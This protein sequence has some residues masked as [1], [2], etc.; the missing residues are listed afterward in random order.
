MVNTIQEPQSDVLRVTEL[1]NPPICKKLALEN[2]ETITA[3]ASE[4]LWSLLGTGIHS[5]LA[6]DETGVL[7]EKRIT[8]E[9][10]GAEH[11]LLSGQVDRFIEKTQTIADYKSTSV[12]SYLFGTKPEWEAQLNLYKYLLET[13]GRTVKKLTI[14]MILRDWQM[15]KSVQA[16]Y[17]KIPFAV[18]DIPVWS[19]DKINSYIKERVAV[20][21][22]DPLPCSPDERWQRKST[23]AVMKEG[24]KSAVRVK[25]TQK[26]AQVYLDTEVKA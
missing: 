16:D 4:F 11:L 24:R 26:E 7:I 14:N 1:I 20:H 23:F 17:P 10:I 18:I 15:S 25:D 3:D 21:Q 8:V 5:V 22:A 12:W 13:T 19:A 9:I 6:K 2:W